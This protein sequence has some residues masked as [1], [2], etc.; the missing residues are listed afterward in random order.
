MVSVPKT[1]P[2]PQLSIVVPLCDDVEAFEATLISVLEN[3]PACSEVIIPHDG[4]YEDPFDLNG[5]VRFVEA[6]SRKFTDL[7]GVA[8]RQARGRFIHLLGQGLLATEGWTLSAIQAFDHFDTAAVAPVIRDHEGKQIIAAG[9]RN[10]FKR[11][12]APCVSLP[13]KKDLL[14]KKIGAYLPASFWRRDV[15]RSLHDSFD[16]QDI[17]ETSMVYHYLLSKAGWRTELAANSSVRSEQS[18]LFGD[19]KTL[20]RGMGLAAIRNH[21][22]RLSSPQIVVSAGISC[23]LSAVSPSNMLESFG[24]LLSPWVSNVAGRIRSESVIACDETGMIVTMPQ[25]AVPT[26]QRHAA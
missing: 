7:V 5:E 15:L 10:G 6:D 2:I 22:C 19:R 17:V 12:G 23:G 24:Q 11:L 20:R 1:N 21:F 3:L 9:W 14:A 26:S 8:A 16:S 13:Q 18:T 4:T 25:T